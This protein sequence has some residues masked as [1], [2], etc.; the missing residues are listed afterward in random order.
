M[1]NIASQHEVWNESTANWYAS[2]YGDWPTVRMPI[3]ALDWQPAETVIDIGCGT[4]SSLRHLLTYCPKGRLI[5]IDPSATMLAIAQEQTAQL[6]LSE[7]IEYHQAGAEL[8]SLQDASA[9]TVLAFSSFHHWKNSVAGLTEVYRVLKPGGRLLLSE[10]PEML[11]LNN[12][13][14]DMIER[15]LH[16]A[17]FVDLDKRRLSEGE[18][19]CELLLVRKPFE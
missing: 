5:G 11:I 12:M 16:A 4:G 14:L 19:W 18:A 9:D 2:Q 6:G 13:T 7:R 17:G 10:E 1:N 15:Q 3:D 8:L